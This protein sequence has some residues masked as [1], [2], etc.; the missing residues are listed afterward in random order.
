MNLPQVMDEGH[1]A[2]LCYI[3]SVLNARVAGMVAENRQREV[4][5]Y[6]PAFTQAAFE[7]VIDEADAAMAALGLL[8]DIHGKTLPHAPTGEDRRPG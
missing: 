6:S 7:A 4:S 1:G 3:V 2:Q 5:G 8:T